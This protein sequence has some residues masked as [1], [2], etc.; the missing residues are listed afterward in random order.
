MPLSASASCQS[1]ELRT[2]RE[3][4]P[5]AFLSAIP[6]PP[7]EA[8]AMR[9]TLTTLAVIIIVIRKGVQVACPPVL[10]RT[11]KPGGMLYSCLS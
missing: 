3:Q 11:G 5:Q 9:E 7:A 2:R 1:R 10:P 8:P 4:A 6:R